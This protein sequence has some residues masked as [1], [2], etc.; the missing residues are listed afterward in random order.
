MN[1]FSEDHPDNKVFTQ[2]YR[3]LLKACPPGLTKDDKKMIRKA[4]YLAIDAH[5]GMVRKSGEPYVF[6]PI[7]V[8]T[9][10]ARNIGLGTTSVISALLHDIVEDTDYTLEDIRSMFGD[11]IT[12]IV[13]GLTK[14]SG[15]FGSEKTSKSMQAE[16]FR[17][18]L[19]TLSEDVR[20][21]LIKL[22]DRLHNMR[23]LDSL[24][25]QKQ[26][27]IASETSYIYAP[28]AH[29]LGLY[30][31]KS[32]M[33]D[34]VMKHT[35]P[36]IFNSILHQITETEAE[37]K[38]F[39]NQFIFPVKQSLAKNNM[40]SE[41]I[42]RMKSISS[43]WTKMKTKH[44]P[45]EEIYDIFAIRI[46]IDCPPENEKIECMKTLAIVESIYKRN[47]ERYRN[48]LYTPK[49]NG[50]QALHTTVMSKTGKWVEVQI[51]S[52]RMDEIAEKGYAAHWKYKEGSDEHETALDEWLSK[53]REVLQRPETDAV[54]FL[55]N[56]KMNLFSDEIFL[57]TPKGDMKTLPKGSTA[58]DFAYH[59]HSNI[60]NKCIGAKVNH[61]LVSLNHVLKSG[62]QVEIITSEKQIPKEDWLN[63]ATTAKALSQIKQGLKDERKKLFDLGKQRLTEMF[64]QINLEYSDKYVE[65]LRHHLDYPTQQELILDAAVDNIRMKEVKHAVGPRTGWKDYF[66]RPFTKLLP[67]SFKSVQNEAPEKK[68][69]TN[70]IDIEVPEV[71]I[72]QA[73][74][75][76][77][78][79][80]DDIIG[81]RQYDQIIVH[82]TGCPK[83]KELS[84][85]YGHKMVKIQWS[86]TNTLFFLASI[87]IIGIDKIGI[88]RDVSKT[89]SEEL[90]VN[91]RN[92]N[93]ESKDNIFEGEIKLFISDIN[94]LK[95]LIRKLSKID[96][97]RQVF[98][99]E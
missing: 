27:R 4:F 76:N 48:W 15:I 54:D 88:I 85:M 84:S 46:I 28:L 96:G 83:A 82:R 12:R 13:D 38:R 80:G 21:I 47:P 79:P 62:D 60:G 66:I 23:T 87:K 43:I 64:A 61:K 33:E 29:R 16:N 90:N 20:V 51:R 2:K 63:F 5:K 8:A 30:S 31:I 95:Q 77:P 72:T 45:F 11:K 86:E 1:V 55:D 44:V 35:E 42:G 19:L 59:I 39:I 74:C 37:R 40:Q 89:I 67:Q 92:F 98:R 50:Y 41:I 10:A 53:I 34:L 9:I 6:H 65:M 78:I 99:A 22:A 18:I 69:N 24:P 68:T 97:V 7:E 49:A 52:K 91:I 32:E 57:F 73:I 70:E 56:F 17:K 14:I 26:V 93:L 36:E 75:C 71:Q 81:F 58:L 25:S 94:Q 3:Q